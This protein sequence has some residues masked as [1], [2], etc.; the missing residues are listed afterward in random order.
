MFD[1]PDG[2]GKSTIVAAYIEGLRNRGF[3]VF[4]ITAWS[5]EH[6]RLPLPEDCES[7]DVILGGEPTRVWI[8]SA[9]RE[10][11]IRNGTGYGPLAVAEAF[12]LDRLVLYQ[13]LYLP[14]RKMGKIIVADRGISTSIAYQP[15]AGATLQAVIK[16]KGNA[17]AI[18][19][20][21]SVLV[22]ADCPVSVA[23]ERLAGRTGKADNAIFERRA[24]IEK[25]RTRYH[26]PVFQTFWRRLGTRII[27]FNTAIPIEE[28]KAASRDLFVEI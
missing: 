22:I 8:G 3:K 17:L 19:N 4:D 20:P 26:S 21:P 5:Q 7:A 24:F 12:S 14:L 16:L 15:L 9:I 13:R 10:E 11:L 23:L 18:K 2:S 28:M 25:L 6:G 27:Y 1:G